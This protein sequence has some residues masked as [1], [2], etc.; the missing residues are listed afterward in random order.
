MIREGH[1]VSS[2]GWNNVPFTTLVSTDLMQQ[3]TETNKIITNITGMYVRMY[4]RMFLYAYPTKKR[5]KF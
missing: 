2:Q 3:L 4:A 1:D 5:P